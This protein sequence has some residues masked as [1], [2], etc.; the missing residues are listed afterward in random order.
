M[1]ILL[2]HPSNYEIYKD[3]DKDVMKK[4]KF[5]AKTEPIGLLYIAGTLLANNYDVKVLDAEHDNLSFTETIHAII[6]EEPDVLGITCTTPLINLSLKI[7][8]KIRDYLPVKVVIGGPHITALPNEVYKYVDSLIVGEGEYAFLEL[9]KDLKKGK[10]KK[11]YQKPLIENLDEIPFPYRDWSI[12][13]YKDCSGGK[14]RTMVSSRGCP[15]NCIFCG[16]KIMFGQKTRFRSPENVVEEIKQLKVNE[17]TMCDDTFTLDRQRTIKMCE[18]IVN[19]KLDMKFLV[20]SRANTIDRG[21]LVWLKR[22]GVYHI[23]FGIESGSQK[24]LNIMKKGITLE[25]AEKAIKLTKEFGI[26]TYCSYVL[27]CPGETKQTIQETLD[28]A[29]KLDSDYAQFSIATPYPGTELWEIAKNKGLL[30]NVDYSKFSWYYNKPIFD[31]EGLTADEVIEIQR[32]AY[33]EYKGGKQGGK[34][35]SKK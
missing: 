10:I 1:K 17:I 35:E 7:A 9:I 23:T 13:Y 8:E 12:N 25:Q 4:D 2:L 34:N 11:I 16:S 20:S 3:I 14:Y 29:K 31:V 18:K 27:G 19:E 21:M 33:E 28:F 6:R 15:Y 32:K 5:Q 30:K 22:A 26:E 24:I